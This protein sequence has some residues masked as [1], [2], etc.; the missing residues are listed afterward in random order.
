MAH[1]P[2]G[3]NFY[4]DQAAVLVWKWFLKLTLN[5]LR[6]VRDHARPKLLFP[7]HDGVQNHRTKL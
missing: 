2:P 7:E 5:R 6:K 1:S 3:H 4:A